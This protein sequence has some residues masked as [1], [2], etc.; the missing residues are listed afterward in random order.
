MKFFSKNGSAGFVAVCRD[1]VMVAFR[2][3]EEHDKADWGHD[4]DIGLVPRL[5]GRVHEGFSNSLDSLWPQ[6]SA[7]S[8]RLVTEEER[9]VFLTGHSMGG[10]M[11]TLA[12]LE[13]AN[14][15]ITPRAVYTYGSPPVG[16]AA[17]A[18]AYDKAVPGT[19]RVVNQTDDVPRLLAPGYE[20]VGEE[21]YLSSDGDAQTGTGFFGKFL[22]RF[23][24]RLDEPVGAG[25]TDHRM[26]TYEKMLAQLR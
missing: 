1:R 15:G 24:R 4:L 18:A 26:N 17:F 25:I 11:A 23:S 2:G 7:E 19:H 6:M 22:D 3:T 10:A 8:K 9:P 5:G 12:A 21:R 20:H 13:L 14:D 16:D